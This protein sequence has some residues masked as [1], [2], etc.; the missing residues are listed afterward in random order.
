V[1][2]AI[3]IGWDYADLDRPGLQPVDD[4]RHTPGKPGD[5]VELRIRIR[6]ERVWLEPPLRLSAHHDERVLLQ[7]LHRIEVGVEQPRD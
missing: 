5:G 3:E 2:R 6:R 4:R 7:Q 1:L